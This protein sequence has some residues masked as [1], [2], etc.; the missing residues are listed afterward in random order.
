M[1]ILNVDEVEEPIKVRAPFRVSALIHPY[2]FEVHTILLSRVVA[3]QKARDKPKS[4][5]LHITSPASTSNIPTTT[6]PSTQIL[7]KSTSVLETSEHKVG[8]ART[9]L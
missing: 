7:R 4:V 8:A 1:D 6:S 9:E 3:P 2:L 5:T